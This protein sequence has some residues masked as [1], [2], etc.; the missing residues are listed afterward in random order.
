[1]KRSS[2]VFFD[3][4]AFCSDEILAIAR[5][6]GTQD[7]NFKT[8]TKQSYDPRKRPKQVPIQVI[9]ASSQD[10]MDTVFYKNYKEYAKRM[11]AGDRDFFVC[12]MPCTTAFTVFVRGKEYPPLLSRDVVETALKENPEKARREYF[13]IPTM[14]GGQNQI[15][16]W[17]TIRRNEKLIIPHATWKPENKIILAFDPARTNDNSIL[18]A[19]QVYEDPDYGICG[20]IINCV[21]FVDTASKKK[22]KLDSN[23]QVDLLR[24]YLLAYNGDNPDYEYIDGLYVDSGSGGG[25]ISAYADTLLNNFLGV[26]GKNHRGLIDKTH[27]IYADYSK[28]YRDAVDKIRLIDPRKYRT[29][30]VEEMI[31]LMHL[32]VIRFPMEYS[33]QDF[34]RIPKADTALAK[35][36]VS[37]NDQE[38]EM[39]VYYLS[40]DE[41][42][43]LTQID[44]MKQEITSIYKISNPENTSVRYALPKEKENKMHKQHCAYVA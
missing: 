38:E 18:S 27:E 30:M 29:Q 11:I 10:G 31:E 13:N 35:R 16:K 5:A 3:E 12:D 14:D 40:Q 19:M 4:A 43:S 36:G 26:D 44:L 15:V 25:G 34:L 42:V 2:V 41:K 20:D 6:F 28:I 7:S 21:N 23:R 37:G 33:G 17:A 8:S 9:Y 22:Y 32:G 1:M 39:E 24:Q